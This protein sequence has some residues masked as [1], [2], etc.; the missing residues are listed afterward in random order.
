MSNHSVLIGA[1]SRASRSPTGERRPPA[2]AARDHGL[3][4]TVVSPEAT[5]VIHA[6][7]KRAS[8]AIAR[9]QSK[10]RLGHF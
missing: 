4:P 8:P 9:R 6:A 1:Q 10:G 5:L 2:P 7:R 3:D